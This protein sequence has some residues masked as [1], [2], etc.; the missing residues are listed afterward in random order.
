MRPRLVFVIAIAST[1]FGLQTHAQSRYGPPSPLP[2]PAPTQGWSAGA[3][4]WPGKTPANP[5]A[6]DVTGSGRPEPL[7][8]WAQREAQRSPA[9]P[10]AVASLPPPASAPRPI[11]ASPTFRPAPA[12]HP[13]SAAPVQS[14]A[15]VPA[16]PA[17]PPLTPLRTPPPAPTASLAP[18]SV[19]PAEKPRA[20]PGYKVPQIAHYPGYETAAAAPPAAAAPAQTASATAKPGPRIYSVGREFGMQP[21]PIPPPTQPVVQG[22][23]LT[24][25]ETPSTPSLAAQDDTDYQ[26][27]AHTESQG[28]TKN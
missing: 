10:V 25:A 6:P 4:N 5:A 8:P 19:Q 12:V 9:A 18:T 27:R 14:S 17:Q 20:Y 26:P 13:G 16:P 21:D 23:G 2:A 7:S 22:P 1:G 28:Q 3:L 15:P 24:L 11:A